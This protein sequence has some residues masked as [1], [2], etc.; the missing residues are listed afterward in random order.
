MTIMCFF[1]FPL[2]E[3]GFHT[4]VCNVEKQGKGCNV[5]Q[6]RYNYTAMQTQKKQQASLHD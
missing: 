1:F 3:T 6:V 4:L 2:A 5:R